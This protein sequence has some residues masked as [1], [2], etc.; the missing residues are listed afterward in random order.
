MFKQVRAAVFPVVTILKRLPHL[1]E[2]IDA[3]VAQALAEEG[4]TR[5]FQVSRSRGIVELFAWSPLPE[6]APEQQFD[7][8]DLLNEDGEWPI[9]DDKGHEIV[10]NG[11]IPYQF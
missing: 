3:A 11:S 8:R 7:P 6:E 9:M 4:D 2:D 1:G 5:P 10:F